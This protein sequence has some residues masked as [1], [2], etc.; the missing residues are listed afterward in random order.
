MIAVLEKVKDRE[1][2]SCEDEELY[3]A[4][5]DDDGQEEFSQIDFATPRRDSELSEDLLNLYM[6]EVGQTQLL[7]AE[8]TKMLASRIED[9]KHLLGL[10]EEWI[11]EHGGRPSDIDL[12]SVLGKRL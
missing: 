2:S 12:L 10:E 1:Q 11:A 7:S 8:E 6:D 4:G 9:G 5:E 3:S